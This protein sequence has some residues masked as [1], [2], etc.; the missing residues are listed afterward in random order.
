VATPELAEE[1]LASLLSH[2]V[3]LVRRRAALMLV[4]RKH[5][6]TEGI[7][8]EAF[9]AVP[10]LGRLGV[11]DALGRLGTDPA[12]ARLRQ[13]VDSRE[14]PDELR[15]ACCA[16]LGQ[17]GDPKSLQLLTTLATPPARG[18]TRIFRSVSPVLRAAA[19]KALAYSVSQEEIRTLLEKLASDA[20]E[21]VRGAAKEALRPT[22]RFKVPAS[23]VPAVVPA[24]EAAAQPEE[25]PATTGFSGLISE[26]TLDQIC[27]V[28]GSSRM[29][30]LL[31]TN[32]EG[33]TAKVYFD[34]GLVVSADFEG[35]KD[36]EAF[37]TF[38]GLKEGAFVFKPGERTLEP[39]MKVSVDQVL[40]GA[41][42]ASHPAQ[43]T[44]TQA[45]AA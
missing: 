4:E 2:P 41:F 9:D 36:Q 30:G 31:L 29:T 35:K 19:A 39:R 38:F 25:K 33:P 5:P 11:A 21:L 18:L 8:L 1:A 40:M 23:A 43:E 26:I 3:V 17:A 28:I 7:L 24:T 32:F 12:L 45:G 34:K 27:Q 13:T 10:P 20:D 15:C 16:A 44:P 6:R 14:M 37:N 22:A 42:G